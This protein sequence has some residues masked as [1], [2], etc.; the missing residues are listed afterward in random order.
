MH[1]SDT[2]TDVKYLYG[3]NTECKKPSCCRADSGIP[4]SV[5]HMAKYWGTKRHCDIPVRTFNK[6]TEFL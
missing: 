4:D 6:F 1:V 3:A 5:S 2:H